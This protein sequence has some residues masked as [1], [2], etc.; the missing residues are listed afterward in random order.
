MEIAEHEGIV[1]CYSKAENLN[2]YIH[3]ILDN[4]IKAKRVIKQRRGVYP[5]TDRGALWYKRQ[6]GER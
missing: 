3:K 4:F 5:F 2:G 6:I 1:S